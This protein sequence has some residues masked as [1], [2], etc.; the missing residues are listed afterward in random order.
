[1]CKYLQL[2]MRQLFSLKLKHSGVAEGPV[3]VTCGDLRLGGALGGPLVGF[4]LGQRAEE[5]AVDPQMEHF[6]T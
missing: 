2:Y 1:M 6:R 5:W 4:A 3:A